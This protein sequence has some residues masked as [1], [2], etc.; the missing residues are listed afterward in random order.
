MK[1][2]T[3]ITPSP[4]LATIY[5]VPGIG[6]STIATFAP[7]PLFLDVEGGL[8]RIDCHKLPKPKTFSDLIDQLRFAFGNKDYQTIVIDTLLAVSELIEQ[9]VLDEAGNPENGL[10]N[11]K[12]FPYDMAKSL[13]CA[14]WHLF[15]KVIKK[16]VDESGKNVLCIGHEINETVANPSGDNF[17]RHSINMYKNAVGFFVADMD[18]VLFAHYEK[19]FTSKA[20]TEQKVVRKTGNRILITEEQLFCVGKNRMNLPPEITFNKPEEISGL[21]QKLESIGKKND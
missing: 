13:L 16:I 2:S 1:I 19:I 5:G 3:G 17:S 10:K 14:K 8:K 21:F 4:W 20:G 11:T 9:S 7:T 6:K 15:I 18:A 12:K